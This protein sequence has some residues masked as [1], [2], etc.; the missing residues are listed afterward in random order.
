MTVEIDAEA[1]GNV[2]SELRGI[3]QAVQSAG[4]GGDVSD[5]PWPLNGSIGVLVSAEYDLS[6]TMQRLVD[7]L[8]TR[9]QGIADDA[10]AAD[11][12]DSS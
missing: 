6:S 11:T 5:V 7:N 10:V 3:A 1:T 8:A 9:T 4:G 2:A 12:A